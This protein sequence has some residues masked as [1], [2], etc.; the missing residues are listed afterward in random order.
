MGHS[1]I[2]AM[3]SKREGLNNLNLIKWNSNNKSLDGSLPQIWKGNITSLKKHMQAILNVTHDD[4]S[5][6]K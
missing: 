3:K 1:S 6:Y 4:V 2:Q 5:S